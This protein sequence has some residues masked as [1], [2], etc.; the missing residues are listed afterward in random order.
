MENNKGI[1]VE[2]GEAIET[3][4]DIF[5]CY[6]CLDLFDLRRL[7]QGHDNNKID[8]LDFNENKEIRELYRIKKG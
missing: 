3:E 7:W 1:C 2:C 5:L 8:A 6:E 4:F